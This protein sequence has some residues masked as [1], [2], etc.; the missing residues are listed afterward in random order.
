MGVN[1]W[2]KFDKEIDTEGLAKDVEE[3]AENGGRREVPHDTYEVEIN[4]MELTTS[5]KGD[6]M[7]TC[8]MKILDGEYKGSLIFMNQVVMQG[9]QIHIVNEFLRSLVSEVQE[10]EKPDVTFKTY[11]QYNDVIM[12]VWEVIDGNFEYLLDY[13]ENSKGY[14]VFEIKEVYVLED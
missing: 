10:G 6:A 8:W 1:I 3:A 14:N 7:F 2:D 12:D 9:F 11:N 13:R 4:K 5:K